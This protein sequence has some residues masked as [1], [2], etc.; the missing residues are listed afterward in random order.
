MIKLFL[1]LSLAVA[2]SEARHILPAA[3]NASPLKC[4]LFVFSDALQVNRLPTRK[5]VAEAKYRPITP[6]V[7]LMINPLTKPKHDTRD[8]NESLDSAIC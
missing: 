5:L 6:P 4:Y 7:D 8:L 1:M 3:I 2:P